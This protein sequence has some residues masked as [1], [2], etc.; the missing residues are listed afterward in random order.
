[1]SSL[2]AFASSDAA[3]PTLNFCHGGGYIASVAQPPPDEPLDY[4]APGLTVR[5]CNRLRCRGCG[6]WVR[7]V[8]NLQLKRWPTPAER[9]EL[10]ELPD[11]TVCPLLRRASARLYLC[12]CHVHEALESSSLLDDSE[13]PAPDAA[14][15]AAGIHPDWACAGHP[16]ATLP[17]LIDGI[18]VTPDGVG[19]VTLRALRG[20]LFPGASQAEHWPG[21][22]AARLYIRLAQTPYQ[23]G[24]LAALSAAL[25]DPAPEVRVAALNSFSIL[26]LPETGDRALSLLKGDRALFAGVPDKTLG[27]EP[28]TQ[29][30]KLWQLAQSLCAQPGEARELAK[31]D[32]LT[33]GRWNATLYS[34]LLQTEPD[35][36]AERMD[37]LLRA[38][39]NGSTHL[40]KAVQRVFVNSQSEASSARLME[41]VRAYAQKQVLR[42]GG[43]SKDLYALLASVSPA[44]LVAQLEAIVA[45]SP[46]DVSQLSDA[47][48]GLPAH[49]D[50]AAKKGAQEQLTQ[51]ARK[52]VLTPEQGSASLY[53]QLA[54][55]DPHWFAENLDRL[56]AANPKDLVAIVQAIRPRVPDA[57][58]KLAQSWL[59]KPG[60]WDIALYRLLLRDHPQWFATQAQAMASQN[61]DS[62]PALI[63]A[64]NDFPSRI[65]NYQVLRDALKAQAAAQGL[66]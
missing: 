39:P 25:T 4:D 36:V 55:A 35:W 48:R 46:A 16:L 45:A 7:S 15:L 29:E 64:I 40:L 61:P 51:L 22:W 30:H 47:L 56:V 38:N 12:R 50:V 49:F 44:W 3:M 60:A 24:V 11:L 18:E 63:R 17:R 41:A 6:A 42:P 66:E 34:V 20:S 59:K 21:L 26:G 27:A 28:R 13:G 23:K 53:T 14:T 52:R 57:A 65:P 37:D 32:A 54:Q 19:D 33:P 62:I 9:T 10:Y 5:G 2:P 8:F 1:M 31:H 58:V 43:G